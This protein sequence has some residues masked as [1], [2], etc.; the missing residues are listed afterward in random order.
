MKPTRNPLLAVAGLTLVLTLAGSAP[1]QVPGRRF[2]DVRRDLPADPG[3]AQVLG[4]G[5]VDC[6]HVIDLLLRNSARR[7]RGVAGAQVAPEATL[8]GADVPGDLVLLDVQLAA[9]ETPDCGPVYQVRL[10]NDSQVAVEQFRI[11]AVAVLDQIQIDSPCTTVVVGC[12]KPA[13]VACVEVK[14]PI[15]A[16]GMGVIHGQRLPFNTLVVAIDSFD[17]WVECD[18]LNNVAILKRAEIV[19]CTVQEPLPDAPVIAGPA[20]DAEVQPERNPRVM[21][22]PAEPRQPGGDEFDLEQLDLG[23]AD[24][25]ATRPAS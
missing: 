12:L 2:P 24:Q 15:A 1:A 10:R 23:E 20:P 8:F 5:R 25:P 21:P 13:E 14:L 22:S 4:W 9:P 18:E 3:T 16:L 17:E 7:V 6:G 19:V 11:S